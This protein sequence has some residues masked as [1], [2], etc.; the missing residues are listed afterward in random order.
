MWVQPFV[1]GSTNYASIRAQHFPQLEIVVPPVTV[2][3]EFVARLDMLAQR[4]DAALA[5]ISILS[6]ELASLVT[7]VLTRSFDH[8][9]PQT[10]ADSDSA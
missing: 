9:R 2:Q 4:L 7:A 5:D 1:K 10:L 6:S 8:T 3:R